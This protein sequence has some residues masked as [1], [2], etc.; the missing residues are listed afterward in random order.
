MPINI[1]EWYDVSSGF[2]MLAR[3]YEALEDARSMTGWAVFQGCGFD[4]MF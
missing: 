4:G 1:M 2:G 3:P